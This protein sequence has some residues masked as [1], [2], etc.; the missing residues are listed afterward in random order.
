MS[1][2]ARANLIQPGK[3]WGMS[4]RARR[5]PG[6]GFG[7]WDASVI[8]AAHGGKLNFSSVFE[9]QRRAN[10]VKVWVTLPLKRDKVPPK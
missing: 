10:R 6:K 8:V 3:R 1:E 7:L 9:W 2:K 4:P 5:A